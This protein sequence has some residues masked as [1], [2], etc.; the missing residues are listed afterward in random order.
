MKIYIS[1]D[2]EGITGVTDWSETRLGEAEHKVARLQMT[3]EALAACEGA[4]QAGAREVYIKDAHD[5]ARNMDI[6]KFPKEAK[7]IRGWTG[8]PASMLVALDESFDAAIF[9]G[10]HSAS[11]EE[12][13]PLAH[14]INHNVLMN[15]KL[16]GEIA[17][18]FTLNAYV[19]AERGVPVVFVSGDKMLCENVKNIVPEIETVAVKQGIGGATINISPEKACESIKD[20]V[21]KSLGNIEKCKLEVKRN[22]HVEMNYKEHLM[23][24]KAMYYPGVKRTGPLTVEY[25]AETMEEVMRTRIFIM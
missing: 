18:E 10:Y 9:I 5:S 20:G 7:L 19:A 15:M 12:G 11:G 25:T 4:I 1:V 3:N 23:A 17:S 2:I 22:I 13:N 8:E 21:V 14:T 24:N 16:D 6:T